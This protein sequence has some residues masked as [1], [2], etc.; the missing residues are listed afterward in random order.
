VSDRRI[1]P[2]PFRFAV[3]GKPWVAFEWLVACVVAVFDRIGGLDISRW[4]RAA[5]RISS[6]G[7]MG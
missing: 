5:R 7:P 1:D 4:R 3:G 6:A 2:D